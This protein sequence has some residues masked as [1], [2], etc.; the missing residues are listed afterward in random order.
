VPAILLASMA[1]MIFPGSLGALKVVVVDR[2]GG[3]LARAMIRNV[4]S[5]PRLDLV[6]VTPQIGAALSA[7]RRERAQ[8]VL[9]IPRDVGIAR[10]GRQPI[11]ILYQA[12]FLAA[13]SL[14]S[15]YLELAVGEALARTAAGQAHLGFLRNQKLSEL[16]GRFR[17]AGLL[18][19]HERQGLQRLIVV[20]QDHG[21]PAAISEM[22]R[23]KSTQ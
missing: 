2:D 15:T 19:Q 12:Q 23:K 4:E 9:V 18:R 3:P 17:I 10:P 13:G 22:C 5:S 7:V 21:D 20:W 11:E 8:A 16:R 6:G 1:A 14:T